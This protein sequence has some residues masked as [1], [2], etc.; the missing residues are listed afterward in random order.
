MDYAK[1]VGTRIAT[2][3]TTTLKVREQPGLEETVLGL[4]PIEDELIVTELEAI[5]LFAAS[6]AAL[7]AASSFSSLARSSSMDSA[8]TNSVDKV[9]YSLGC[10]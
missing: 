8:F 7:L 2:V 10:Q 4:V 6:C 3:T 1:E 5:F 9:T